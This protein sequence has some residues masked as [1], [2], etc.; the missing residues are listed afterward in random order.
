MA[1]DPTACYAGYAY[2]SYANAPST[3][4]P[5]PCGKRAFEETL[6]PMTF[7]PPPPLPDPV[8]AQTPSTPQIANVFLQNRVQPV[9]P[10][11]LAPT[12]PLSAFPM[13]PP[14]EQPT[15]RGWPHPHAGVFSEEGGVAGHIASLKGR[16]D[17]LEE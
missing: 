5:K 6:W 8:L 13:P 17:N 16:F 14:Q 1:F 10:P 7:M 11:S 3:E 15:A 9:M 12:A 2:T 4:P